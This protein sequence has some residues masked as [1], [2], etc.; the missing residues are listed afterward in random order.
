MSIDTNVPALAME[1]VLKVSLLVLEK[2]LFAFGLLIND[3]E[4][5]T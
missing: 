4:L 2:K 3:H 1:E 5:D